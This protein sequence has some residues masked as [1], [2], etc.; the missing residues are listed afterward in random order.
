MPAEQTSLVRIAHL[1]TSGE[2]DEAKRLLK[3]FQQWKELTQQGL[4]L[5]NLPR[6]SRTQ[7]MKTMQNCTLLGCHWDLDGMYSAAIAIC[8]GGALEG[9]KIRGAF[10]RLRL[11]RYGFRSLDEYTEALGAGKDET[12]VIIDYAAHPQAALTLDHHMTSLSYWELGAPIPTGIYEPSMPSCPR[13]LATFCGLEVSEE[14]LCGC[15]L[16]DG[17]LYANVA[18]ASDLSHPFVALEYALS[19][20]VSEPVAKKVILTLAENQL[21]PQSVLSQ[22]V[23]KARLALVALELEEQRSFWQKESRFRHLS[24][25]LS[26]ADARLAPHSATRFRYLPF[27]NSD[28]IQRAYLVTIRPQSANRVNL[29]ISRNPF[30]PRSPRPATL[31]RFSSGRSVVC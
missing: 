4:G 27:E 8:L 3:S 15:D 23:W 7:C 28:V 6:P 21:D 30:L 9:G 16:V 18:Q 13:L 11:F 12:T 17:A 19:V 25:L 20:D 1:V 31:S 10:G 26:V 5:G 29:G 14:V 24:D 2:E 22:A